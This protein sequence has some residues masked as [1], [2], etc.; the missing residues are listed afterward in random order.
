MTIFSEIYGTYY[1]IAARLLSRESVSDGDVYGVIREDGFRDSALFLPQKL[2]PQRD[3]SDW[4]LLKRGNDGLLYPIIGK[5][6]RVLTKLQKMWLKA[7]LAD[8]R[9]R[10]FLSDEALEALSKRLCDVPSLYR[11]EQFRVF[12]RFSDGDDYGNEV[13]RAHFQTILKAIKEKRILKINFTSGHGRRMC[14]LCLPFKLEYSEKNDK[15]RVYSHNVK[16]GRINGGGLINV[17]R[18]DEIAPRDIYRGELPSEDE[19]FRGIRAKEPIRIYVSPER[20][21]VERFF[22]EFAEY[23]KRADRD[24]ESGGCTV[25]L[26]YDKQDET[27]ILIQLLGFGAALEILSPENIRKQAAERVHKQIKLLESSENE[28]STGMKNELQTQ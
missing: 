1:R 20:N 26:Y 5:P 10:L 27:E 19:F 2:L 16:N 3:G 28:L 21:A 25:D 13:Y 18:I 8:P 22:N 6:P 9:M 17:G 12:D 24:L 14:R 4:G 15:F 23:E 7:K 11:S